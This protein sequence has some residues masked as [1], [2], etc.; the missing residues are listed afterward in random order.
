[1]LVF[2][3]NSRFCSCEQTARNG[4]KEQVFTEMLIR[5]TFTPEACLNTK[6]TDAQLSTHGKIPYS[7]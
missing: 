4:N 2:I 7:P 6:D 1:M 3:S 5:I